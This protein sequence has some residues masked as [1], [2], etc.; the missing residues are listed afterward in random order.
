MGSRS[1]RT[2][3]RAAAPLPNVEKVRDR[4]SLR[5][6]GRMSFCQRDRSRILIPG[7]APARN[8]I[9]PSMTRLEARRTFSTIS[10]RNGSV[11]ER[12]KRQSLTGRSRRPAGRGGMTQTF[13]QR[14]ATVCAPRRMGFQARRAIRQPGARRSRSCP[15]P[16]CAALLLTGH[17]RADTLEPGKEGKLAEILAPTR[18]KEPASHVPTTPRT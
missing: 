10:A 11:L 17:A 16:R 18:A 6:S 3:G 2:P 8:G 13:R 14:R 15:F 7:K 4:G 12:A 5:C 1:Y 9:L